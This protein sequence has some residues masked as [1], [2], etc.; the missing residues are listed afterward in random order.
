MTDSW[1]TNHSPGAFI[2]FTLIAYWWQHGSFFVRFPERQA[3]CP[4]LVKAFGPR[5]T[6]Y[7]IAEFLVRWLLREENVINIKPTIWVFKGLKNTSNWTFNFQVPSQAE[8]LSYKFTPWIVFYQE[9]DR[10]GGGD[11]GGGGMNKITFLFKILMAL[12]PTQTAEKN[13]MTCP[14]TERLQN[15]NPPSAWRWGD[16]TGKPKKELQKWPIVTLIVGEEW[17][18]GG[19]TDKPK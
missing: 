7:F 2:I 18:G 8:N 5:F 10:G 11:G 13:P 19:D 17:G 6:V 14:R 1:N 9:V 16:N 3:G 12:L 4:R 15:Q